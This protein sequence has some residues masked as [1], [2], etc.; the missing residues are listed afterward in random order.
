MTLIIDL[1]DEQTLVLKANAKAQGLST[2][3]YA[4]Q[5]LEQGLVPDWLRESWE[6]GAKTGVNQLSMDEIDPEIAAALI[7]ADELESIMETA[8]LLRSP[9]NADRLV[10][11][12]RRA[13]PSRPASTTSGESSGLSGKTERAAIFDPEFREDLRYCI[14][15]DLKMA[16]HLRVRMVP[17]EY[18]RTPACVP[19]VHRSNRFSCQAIS[20]SALIG[21]C[22]RLPSR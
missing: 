5:V 7:T 17:A 6:S 15:T 8:H 2:E 9:A 16:L 18:S 20:L 11:A 12:L 1:P 21:L 19:R 3:Q 4:R 22:T 10:R 14:E 13:R